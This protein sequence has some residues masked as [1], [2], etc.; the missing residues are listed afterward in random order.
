MSEEN[1]GSANPY[2]LDSL[3][4]KLRQAVDEID[5]IKLSFT[6]NTEELSKIKNMLDA[7][8]LKE[9]TTTIQKFEEL[10]SE[11]EKQREEAFRGAKKY[12]D[13]LEKEKER[14]I[15]LWDAY[16]NQEEELSKTE[17]K[18]RE[19]RERAEKAEAEKQQL[20]Q[21][22]NTRL[23]TLQQKLAEYD[24]QIKQ[25]SD[26]KKRIEEF[27]TIRNQLEEENRSLKENLQTKENTIHT[28][29]DQVEKLKQLEQHAQYKQ[30][31][32]ELSKEYEKEKERLTKL[33][34]LYE[35]TEREC[36][37][38][39]EQAKN[40]ESWYASNREIFTKLFS[41]TPPVTTPQASGGDSPPTATAN[42]NVPGR[43]TGADG[44]TVKQAD[45]STDDKKQKKKRLR[46]RIS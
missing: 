23:N 43:A 18:L 7:G 45:D 41:T 10:L 38:L 3:E 39:K 29:Q 1:R 30:K 34:H 26:Y 4:Q 31:Y 14:L 22:Y 35:E 36:N 16:K 40:W 42:A 11:A 8:F 12:S 37:R 33:Y 15:K 46:F 9:I 2:E 24:E 20:E 32:D 6:K 17:A 13:E 27:D 28:L 19:F 44:T 5:N 21:E 25:F